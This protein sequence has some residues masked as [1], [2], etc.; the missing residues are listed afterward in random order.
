MSDI[1]LELLFS[2]VIGYCSVAP[3]GRAVTFV[4]V[5]SWDLIDSIRIYF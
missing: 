1:T 4:K 5:E 3:S 2:A